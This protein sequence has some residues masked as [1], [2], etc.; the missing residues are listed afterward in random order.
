VL[1]DLEPTTQLWDTGVEASAKTSLTPESSFSLYLRNMGRFK[2]L[3]AREERELTERIAEGDE[4]AREKL[5]QANLRL[6][7]SVARRYQG[8]GLT[9]PDLV[10]EGFFGLRRASERFDPRRGHKFSTYATIW[11]K[12]SCQKAVSRHGQTI[13][14]PMHV[15]QRRYAL[16]RAAAELVGS[17]G[18]EPT[19][20]ELSAWTGIE[21]EHVAE[22]LAAPGQTWSLDQPLIEDGIGRIALVVDEDAVDPL[23]AAEEAR[24]EAAARESL[25]TLPEL[26]RAILILRHGLSGEEPLAQDEVARRLGVSRDKVRAGELSA[27]QRLKPRLAYLLWGE[28]ASHS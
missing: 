5:L 10:Q 24:R 9:L 16:T 19:R 1:D 12:Q 28:M 2:L 26:E 27:V 11:I 8:R 6:V 21:V 15:D 3:D 20:E 22:A 18:R 14:V 25:E 23:E 4:G 13:A 17:L 7:I